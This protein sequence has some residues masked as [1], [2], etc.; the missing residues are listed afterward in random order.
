M[1]GKREYVEGTINYL[2]QKGTTRIVRICSEKDI[3]CR[4]VTNPNKRG[5]VREGRSV[6][7]FSQGFEQ[8]EGSFQS[9]AEATSD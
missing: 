6:C 7:R 3:K 8:T 5:E 2:H 1:N 4:R 9:A